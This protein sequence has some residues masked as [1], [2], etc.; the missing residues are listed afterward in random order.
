MAIAM[1]AIIG[2]TTVYW[3]SLPAGIMQE[4]QL[5]STQTAQKGT[6]Y[7]IK[8]IISDITISNKEQTSLLAG[9]QKGSR[10]VVS[11]YQTDGRTDQLSL[12]EELSR[13]MFDTSKNKLDLTMPKSISIALHTQNFAGNQHLQ[14]QEG[15]YKRVVA[16]NMIGKVE[17]DLDKEISD[18]LEVGASIGDVII[19]VPTD[20]GIRLTTQQY[21]GQLQLPGTLQETTT[22]GT[23]LGRH[24]KHFESIGYQNAARKITINCFNAIGNITIEQTGKTANT[25]V[26]PEPTVP[27]TETTEETTDI[28]I[29]Y[30]TGTETNT[31]T[32]NE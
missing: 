3:Q 31:G 9:K 1:I 32:Q 11:D 28:E 23:F 29:E 21:H 7:N 12:T 20:I 25:T 13:T 24:K 6:Q 4:T 18:Y 15:T 14:L 22:G 19:R 8:G 30:M 17:V 5:L 10:Q 26:I 2:M 27:T 16:H